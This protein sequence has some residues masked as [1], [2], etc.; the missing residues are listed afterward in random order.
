ME[1]DFRDSKGK[2]RE[3]AEF[4]L[5]RKDN[6]I[7]TIMGATFYHKAWKP[8]TT[9]F[10]YSIHHLEPKTLEEKP[11]QAD[12]EFANIKEEYPDSPIPASSNSQ[13]DP[14]PYGDEE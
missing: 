12:L 13:V 3:T 11:K 7:T 6:E 9:N 14:D 8:M 10:L 4:I 1:R 2:P 5:R